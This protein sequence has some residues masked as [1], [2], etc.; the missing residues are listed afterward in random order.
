LAPH[1]PADWK[2]VDIRNL[3]VGGEKLDLR[4]IRDEG[5]ITLEVQASGSK[6]CTIDFQP[7][8]SWRAKVL[9]VE[10]DGHSAQFHVKPNTEDQ[11]V[12]VHVTVTDGSHKLG[13]RTQDDFGLSYDGQLPELGTASQGLRILSQQ[14]NAARDQL[15]IETSG[16][17][18]RQYELSIWNGGQIRSVSGARLER[19]SDGKTVLLLDM[20][21]KEGGR[22]AQASVT[23]QLGRSGVKK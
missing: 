7:A 6:S 10:W 11:H 21:N 22:V 9:G 4:E 18:G 23:I 17:A 8:V 14:W 20:P 16:I 2:S 13:I 5:G 12:L 15:T 3:S 1:L 19:E